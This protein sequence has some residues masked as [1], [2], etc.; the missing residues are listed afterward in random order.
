M[1]TLYLDKLLIRLKNSNIGCSIN[2]CYT[3]A[4]SYADDITLSCLSIRGLNRMLEICNSFAAEHNL[5]FNTK[6]L[7]GIKYGDLICASETIYSILEKILLKN[8]QKQLNSYIQRLG[9]ID[10]RL[11][12]VKKE[13]TKTIDKLTT[14]RI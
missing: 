9:G 10:I 13:R 4:L 11:W 3:G 5:I 2:G 7:L 12:W 8:Q 6:K 14:Y 1:F